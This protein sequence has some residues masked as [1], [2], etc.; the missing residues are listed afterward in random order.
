VRQFFP[1]LFITN[2]IPVASILAATWLF[3]D[4]YFG[5]RVVGDWEEHFSR[6]LKGVNL[7]YHN[8]II[9]VKTNSALGFINQRVRED[10]EGKAYREIIREINQCALPVS[11]MDRALFNSITTETPQLQE[12]Q[13]EANDFTTI[14]L[15]FYDE[16]EDKIKGLSEVVK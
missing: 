14:P 3:I 10:E 2:G 8:V 16:Y 12:S 11:L 6:I 9:R 4:P 13:R 1:W 5:K 7:G 15:S